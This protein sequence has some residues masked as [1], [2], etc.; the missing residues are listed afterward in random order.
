MDLQKDA[1]ELQYFRGKYIKGEYQWRQVFKQTGGNDQTLSTTGGEELVYELAPDVYNHY[2]DYIAFTFNVPAGGATLSN[3]TFA[4]GVPFFR[5]IQFYTTGSAPI[6]WINEADKYSNMTF[7]R[8][9]KFDEMITNDKITDNAGL[10][11]LDAG[12]IFYGLN[13]SNSTVYRPTIAAAV[14]T[15]SNTLGEPLY[16]F[17]ARALNAAVSQRVVVPLRYFKD[18]WYG[19][20]KD[21][22]L[23]GQNIYIKFVLNP[24]SKI[25]YRSEAITNPTLNAVA[26]A[27][28]AIT[29]T[30]IYYY[31]C[32]ET[33]Q[34]IKQSVIDKV[35]KEG[36]SMYVPYINFHK[37]DL[38]NTAQSIDNTYYP[39]NGSKLL[40]IYWAPYATA[41]GTNNAY[42]HD[43]AWDY[44]ANPQV[45]SKIG[46]FYTEINNVRTTPFNYSIQERMDWMLQS[47]KLKG[48][49]ILSANEYY[50]NWVWVEDFT[51]NDSTVDQDAQNELQN[52]STGLDLK[53]PIQWRATSTTANV[54]LTH[55]VYGVTLR[56]L[57]IKPGMV[58]FMDAPQGPLSA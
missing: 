22:W 15:G 58:Q 3:W 43:C 9:I 18:S 23:G 10:K 40:K 33:N 17:S 49:S 53:N 42:D 47:R 14:T 55:Y 2:N 19:I 24:I 13:P 5:E 8:N 54:A 11:S 6:I 1:L 45:P 56:N 30:N 16:L 48:S 57:I 32:Q 51:T 7:R 36:L 29:M 44:A 52:Y 21:T 12:S 46:N 4:D 20:N 26:I 50:Y 31:A 27:G 28:G 34:A 35:N 38:T 39:A 25:V 41:N 37:K